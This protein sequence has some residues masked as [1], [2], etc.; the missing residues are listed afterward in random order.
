[1]TSA[2]APMIWYV[3]CTRVTSVAESLSGM[4]AETFPSKRMKKPSVPPPLPGT[5]V[6]PENVVVVEAV[7]S[8]AHEAAGIDAKEKFSLAGNQG[9]PTL[10]SNQPPADDNAAMPAMPLHLILPAQPELVFQPYEV[11]AIATSVG[12]FFELYLQ[13]DLHKVTP[14]VGKNLHLI[15]GNPNG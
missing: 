4:V 3:T 7:W 9:R 8:W 5:D 1:M 10:L 13:E 12:D 2:V 11:R 14:L 6:V 15:S